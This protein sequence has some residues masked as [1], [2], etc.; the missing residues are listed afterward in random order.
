[1]TLDIVERCTPKISYQKQDSKTLRIR[2]SY[3]AACTM[4]DT[5]TSSPARSSLPR[6]RGR[7]WLLSLHRQR[8][9]SYHESRKET[10][11]RWNFRRTPVS[12]VAV[13][14]LP[15]FDRL[16]HSRPTICVLHAENDCRRRLCTYRHMHERH[17]DTNLA[18][19]GSLPTIAQFLL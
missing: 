4:W 16:M 12:L 2:R 5:D 11:R 8:C 15:C 7:F 6:S 18:D 3:P 10:A 19:H 9:L 13:A 14:G 1:M 17:L